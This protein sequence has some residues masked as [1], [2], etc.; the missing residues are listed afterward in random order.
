M[1]WTCW[2]PYPCLLS[3]N[4]QLVMKKIQQLH[5]DHQHSNYPMTDTT[6]WP[7]NQEDSR[8]HMGFSLTDMI[9]YQYNFDIWDIMI[10]VYVNLILLPSPASLD[11]KRH[12]FLKCT[13]VLF[14]VPMHLITSLSTYLCYDII[15][16]CWALYMIL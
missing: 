2:T 1:L 5:P 3:K 16:I 8:P 12:F 7:I 4:S 6:K 13:P 9:A 10:C 15:G 14:I 11:T